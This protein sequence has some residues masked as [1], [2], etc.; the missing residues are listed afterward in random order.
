[1]LETHAGNHHWTQCQPGGGAESAGILPPQGR[2]P[3]DLRR[4]AN[5]PLI[6]AYLVLEAPQGARTSLLPDETDLGC[7]PFSR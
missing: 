7:H 4:L 5:S 3:D 1:M 6:D 2:V